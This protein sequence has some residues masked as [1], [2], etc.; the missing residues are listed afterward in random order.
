MDYGKNKI[1][2]DKKTFVLS[3]YRS[4]NTLNKIFREK[5]PA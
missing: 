1:L 3:H 4:Q 5:Y 2:E